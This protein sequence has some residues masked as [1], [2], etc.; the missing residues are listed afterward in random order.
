MGFKDLGDKTNGTAEKINAEDRGMS[1]PH[2]TLN[3]DQDNS[4]KS[5]LGGD[6]DGN[7]HDDYCC[8]SITSDGSSYRSSS[9]SSSP[10]SSECSSS[11]EE[12]EE[13][14]EEDEDGNDAAKIT[15]ETQSLPEATYSQLTQGWPTWRAVLRVTRSRT[16]STGGVRKG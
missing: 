13:E 6:G 10:N 5:N 2:L 11:D 15:S 12:D 14:D 1:T 8:S 9:F 7:S 3:K 16:Q 4:N